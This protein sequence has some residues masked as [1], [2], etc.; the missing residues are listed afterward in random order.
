MNTGAAQGRPAVTRIH[1][2]IEAALD[3][4]YPPR[5]AGCGAVGQGDWCASCDR[6]TPRLRGPDA[7]FSAD[8]G[9][10]FTLDVCSAAH[11]EGK[12]R[13]AIHAFKYEGT[14]RLAAPFGRM[15]SDALRREK[16]SCDLIVAVP[17]HP[18]RRRERGYNQ[19]ELLARAI[20]SAVGVPVDDRGLART[21]NTAHQV[22]L[23]ATE[24]K[25]NVQDAFRAD[26]QR[27]RGRIVLLVDDVF[28][29][30]ATLGECAK[31]LRQAGAF[32]V[33]AATL[34]IA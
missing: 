20:G 24:R 26:E 3:L 7:H 21:R 6:E 16:F 10:G 13:S 25:A 31:A 2:L 34:A 5:C 18:K 14:P 33:R 32:E 12:L 8:V 11:F 22:E 15:L 9:D 28:T 27:V 17:L 4:L 29:T 1:S 19:S 23:S 30:G